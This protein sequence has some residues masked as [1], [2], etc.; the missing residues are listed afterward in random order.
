MQ[1]AAHR[2]LGRWLNAA[3]L[4]IIV[5]RDATI[6]A[7]ES[8]HKE[9][10]VGEFDSSTA[11]YRIFDGEE[12]VRV[13]RTGKF[14]GGTYSA[15][16]ER[17]FGASWSASLTE[18][19]TV[20]NQ[21]LR[22]K[23]YGD[24]LFVAKLDPIG[25]RFFHLSPRVDFDPS[26]PPQQLAMM[27][28]GVCNFA[29]GASV[30]ADLNDVDLYAVHAND[31]MEA[32]SVSE[33]KDY[34]ARRPKK[35][36]DLRAVHGTLLQGSILDVDVRVWK[37]GTKWLVTTNDDRKIVPNAPSQEV[38]IEMAAWAIRRNP[39][40]P[41][42]VDFIMYQRARQYEKHFDVQEE[43]DKVRG[44]F[45]I[46]PRDVLVVTKGSRKLDINQ[47]ETLAVADVW[48]DK[49]ESRAVNLKVMHK[50]KPKTLYAIHANRLADDEVSLLSM[51]G[52]K[53]LVRKR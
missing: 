2:V 37:D 34:V 41:L 53:I 4:K 3:T 26:G 32:L 52:D 20:G 31:Q 36:I 50:G 45:A 39:S 1:S 44:V 6:K 30:V 19:I 38:A 13:L 46:K 23:R 14:T 22:G 47:R 17:S 27:E 51:S 5:D 12:L 7:R 16:L 48:R 8:L 25:M 28:S 11:L 21:Q 15:T 49:G 10:I 29:L 9:C 43:P 33:A 35:D 18:V 24:D 40:R 42:P